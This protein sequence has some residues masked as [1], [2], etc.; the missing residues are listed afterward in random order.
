MSFAKPRSHLINVTL[1]PTRWLSNLRRL[2]YRCTHTVLDL[3]PQKKREVAIANILIVSITLIIIELLSFTPYRIYY[4]APILIALVVFS[5]MTGGIR[6]GLLTSFIT[7]VYCY[8]YFV[9]LEQSFMIDDKAKDLFVVSSIMSP[10]IAVM[11]GILNARSHMLLNEKIYRRKLEGVQRQTTDILESITDAFVTVNKDLRFTYVNNKAQKYLDKPAAELLGKRL[12]NVFST[13]ESVFL[14]KVEKVLAT[15]NSMVIEDFSPL[16]KMWLQIHIYPTRDGASIY[17]NDITEK[18]ESE[19]R[20][21]DFISVASHELRTPVTSIYSLSQLINKKLTTNSDASLK[22]Y[23]LMIEKQADRLVKLCNDLLDVKRFQNKRLALNLEKTDLY[24][25]IKQ[26]VTTYNNSNG[27]HTIS[28]HGKQKYFVRIDKERFTQVMVNL[29][30]NA[31]KYSPDSKK[32]AVR[33]TSDKG[34]LIISIRD[35]GPGI[36]KKHQ[37]N[38]FSQFYRIKQSSSN[39]QEGLGLGLYISSE[40]IKKHG[41]QLWVE[42]EI[43]K[44]STFFI[45]LPIRKSVRKVRK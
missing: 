19:K 13:R 34:H 45:K 42:S 14:K 1:A 24:L 18:K 2:F 3:L 40:I 9:G 27:T 37:K 41:G 15:K 29:M 39:Q 17:F 38:I 36:E 6:F 33:L 30:N 21:D 11:V 20:K 35:Y 10:F 32:V 5:S 26:T 23:S 31:V 8:I 44:G 43:S 12:K 16:L 28:F 22:K 4:P 25:F 7:M